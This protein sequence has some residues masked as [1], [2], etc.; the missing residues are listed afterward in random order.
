MLRKPQTC[1]FFSNLKQVFLILEADPE[2]LYSFF[3][4]DVGYPVWMLECWGA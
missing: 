2:L 3:I 4:Q 1:M